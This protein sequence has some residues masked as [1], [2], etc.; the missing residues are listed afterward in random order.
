[1]FVNFCVNVKFKHSHC[2]T[3]GPF[4]C[5]NFPWTFFKEARISMGSFLESSESPW[6]FHYEHDVEDNCKDCLLEPGTDGSLRL[7]VLPHLAERSAEAE[8]NLLL[9]RYLIVFKQHIIGT[10]FMWFW[11]MLF[12]WFWTHIPRYFKNYSC[13]RFSTCITSCW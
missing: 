11:G 13:A 2:I 5:R 7:A 12:N 10:K 1:M 8:R 3:G 9:H 4:T 6:W